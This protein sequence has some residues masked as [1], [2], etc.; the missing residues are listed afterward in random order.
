MDQDSTM[1]VEE[2]KFL[3]GEGLDVA[4]EVAR[5]AEATLSLKM[6]NKV[7][8]QRWPGPMGPVVGPALMI[9]DLNYT[10]EALSI[11]GFMR[12]WI[13]EQ[14]KEHLKSGGTF[15]NRGMT[16]HDDEEALVSNGQVL[17]MQVRSEYRMAT[18]QEVLDY[19]DTAKFANVTGH[20]VSARAQEK[21]YIL[22]YHEGV[23]LIEAYD[24]LPRQAKVI[25]DLLNDTGREN[26]T[27]ASIEVILTENQ[28]ALKTKQEPMKIFA[29]YRHRLVEEGHLEGIGEE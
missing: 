3:E 15:T 2:P 4:K 23:P 12:P 29:F 10:A 20:R 24:R 8:V 5:E 25:L 26:F 7:R 28:D 1:A 21:G 9:L 19:V 18:E 27:E 14:I 17:G 6:S 16:V 13:V 11:S 22:H